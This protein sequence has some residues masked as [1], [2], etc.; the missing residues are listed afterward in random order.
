MTE[1]EIKYIISEQSLRECMARAYCTPKNEKKV[2]DPT[3]IEAMIQE[4]KDTCKIA[5][6]CI[7]DAST[8]GKL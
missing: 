7:L 3:L 1:Q 8:G 5:S 4:I 2:L 6:I